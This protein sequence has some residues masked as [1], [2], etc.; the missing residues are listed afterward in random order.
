MVNFG[1]LCSL[2]SAVNKFIIIYNNNIVTFNI[3]LYINSPSSQ[4][5]G[6]ATKEIFLFIPGGLPLILILLAWENVYSDLLSKVTF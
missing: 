3:V 5:S 6:Q 1:C 2:S 4:I